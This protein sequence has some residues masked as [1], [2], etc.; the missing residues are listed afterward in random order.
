MEMKTCAI[1]G[2]I[3]G[4]VDFDKVTPPCFNHVA[5]Q[6]LVEDHGLSFY[7]I[8]CD[9]KITDCEVAYDFHTLSLY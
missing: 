9:H 7:A 1:G 2:E 5:R 6:F 3:V 8:R 4:K